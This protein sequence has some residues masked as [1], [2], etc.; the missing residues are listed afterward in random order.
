MRPANCS[1][2]ASIS[3]SVSGAVACRVNSAASIEIGAAVVVLHVAFLLAPPLLSTDI[4]NYV[5]VARLGGR[6]HLDPYVLPPAARRQSSAS[7]KPFS[8]AARAAS[9]HCW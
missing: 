2:S 1:V 4:F 5:D 8:G 3:A 7:A 6:Y 9:R